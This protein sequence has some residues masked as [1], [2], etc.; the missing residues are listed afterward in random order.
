MLIHFTF[1]YI[2]LY[3][4]LFYPLYIFTLYISRK[5]EIAITNICRINRL[6]SRCHHVIFS[7]KSALYL[8]LFR[9]KE[10]TQRQ[11]QLLDL[12][13]ISLTHLG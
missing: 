5:K 3:L 2:K 8:T 13:L 6:C 12:P 1:Y 10:I 9:R 11:Q 7:H 4:D